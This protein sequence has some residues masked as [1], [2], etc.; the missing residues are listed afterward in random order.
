M[1]LYQLEREKGR[2]ASP[3]N[4]VKTIIPFTFFPLM[5]KASSVLESLSAPSPQLPDGYQCLSATADHPPPDK[6]ID[7]HSSLVQTPLPEPGCA[8]PV[9]DQPLVGKGDDSNSPPVDHPVSEEHHS[10]V[11]LVSSESPEL[12]KDFAIPTAPE[13]SDSFPSE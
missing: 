2:F 7:S 13:I 4:F 6:E 11:L 1:L 10:H 12:D 8:Q 5:D 3:V 9:L